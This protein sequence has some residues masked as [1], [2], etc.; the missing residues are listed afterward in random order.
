MNEMYIM[1]LSIHSIGIIILLGVLTLNIHY[2]KT[3]DSLAK[4]KRKMSIFMTPLSATILGVSIFTGVIMMAGKHLE[5]TL[6]N[7]AMIVLSVVLIVLEFKRL[8]ALS[9]MNAKKERAL[10]AYRG[11]GLKIL[12]IEFISIVAMSLWMWVK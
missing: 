4:Y 12:N 2:L 1:G 11:F 9:Y 3:A 5:F 8:K 6:E 10:E 7:I